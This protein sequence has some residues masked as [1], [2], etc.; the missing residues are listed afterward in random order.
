MPLLARA[1]RVDESE[2]KHLGGNVKNC[3]HNSYDGLVTS[4]YLHYK[5]YNIVIKLI[6][7]SNWRKGTVECDSSCTR[8]KIHTYLIKNW[9]LFSITSVV[10]VWYQFIHILQ[11]TLRWT[12]DSFSLVVSKNRFGVEPALNRKNQF[13]PV[14]YN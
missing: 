7:L 14:Q 6:V 4:N 13:I 8:S 2:A 3:N 9:F 1:I 5:R 12:N 10:H 11:H